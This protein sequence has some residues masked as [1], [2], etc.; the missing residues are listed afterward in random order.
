VTKRCTVEKWEADS[1]EVLDA[2][3]YVPT[4]A[5]MFSLMFSVVS[6]NCHGHRAISERMRKDCTSFLIGFTEEQV[7]GQKSLR[8]SSAACRRMSLLVEFTT[9]ALGQKY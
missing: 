2:Q 4:S 8:D 6:D 5:F 1:G 7:C 9:R 3:T